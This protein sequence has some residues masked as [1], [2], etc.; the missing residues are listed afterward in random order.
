VAA[1]H[2]PPVLVLSRPEAGPA[3]RAKAS[4]HKKTPLSCLG[5][6]LNGV[7]VALQQFFLFSKGA[8]I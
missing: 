6:Q 3:G 2:S 7:V 8:E 1:Q 5:K 4:R